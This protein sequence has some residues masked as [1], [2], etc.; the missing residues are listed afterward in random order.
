MKNALGYL[1]LAV[2]A[3]PITESA[4]QD[5]GIGYTY[6]QLDAVYEDAANGYPTAGSSAVRTL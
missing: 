1:T 3:S 6:I 2:L 5:N 4:G